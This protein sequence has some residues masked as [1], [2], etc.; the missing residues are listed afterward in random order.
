VERNLVDQP[1]KH[2]PRSN[3]AY[4]SEQWKRDNEIEVAERPTA[5]PLD[6]RQ[7]PYGEPDHMKKARKARERAA[8]KD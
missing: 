2:T 4:G 5:V 6:Q 8:H 7:Y 3:A 1:V